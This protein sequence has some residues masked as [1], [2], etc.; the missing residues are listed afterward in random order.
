MRTGAHVAGELEQN[1]WNKKYRYN[2]VV[3]ITLE[4]QNFD[5][6]LSWLVRVKSTRIAWHGGDVSANLR[7]L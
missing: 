4:A 3:P 1:V 7:N 6:G 5:Q 2:H